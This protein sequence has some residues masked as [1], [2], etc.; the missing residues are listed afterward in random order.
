M[1]NVKQILT[2]FLAT[3][4]LGV[5]ASTIML[6][7]FQNVHTDPGAAWNT[8][9]SNSASNQALND[10]TGAPS[11]I[12]LSLSGWTS[13]T[14]TNAFSQARNEAPSWDTEA[15]VVNAADDRFFLGASSSASLTLSNLDPNLTYSIE[16]ISSSQSTLGGGGANTA[17]DPPAY[18]RIQDPDG[19]VDAYNGFD[20]TLLT[21]NDPDNQP[22][23]ATAGWAAWSTSYYGNTHPTYNASGFGVEG[24]LSWSNIKPDASG[25]IVLNVQTLDGDSRGAINAMQ[26]TVI[27]EPGTLVL[28]GIALGGLLIFRRRR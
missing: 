24:W 5:Q 14:N 6:V 3:A 10:T 8:I 27:P 22:G 7:D 16:L 13:S 9:A 20:G 19:I 23:G 28:V 21:N 11:G 4:F 1:T 25:Q 18:Y 12:N 26:I 17:G 15:N 2:A